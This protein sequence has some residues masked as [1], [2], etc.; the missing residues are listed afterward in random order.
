MENKG[1]KCPW[2]ISLEFK[3]REKVSRN[4]E[5]DLS[6]KYE[7][8]FSCDGNKETMEKYCQSRF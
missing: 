6:R 2:K 4:I 8:C 1:D 3:L 7:A 5:G